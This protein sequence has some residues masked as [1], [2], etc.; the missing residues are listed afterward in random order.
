MSTTKKHFV[1]Y[2]MDRYD[3]RG[4]ERCHAV[5]CCKNKNLQDL[6]GGKFCEN[7]VNQLSIIRNRLKYAKCSGNKLLEILC[8]QEEIE[9]RKFCD[10]GHMLYQRHLERENPVFN[11]IF[12]K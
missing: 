5:G 2:N 6:F 9:L 1:S 4:N 3:K 10:P 11:E 8:R 12:Y 7:H